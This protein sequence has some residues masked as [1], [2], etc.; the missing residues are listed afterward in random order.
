TLGDK[1]VELC[2]GTHVGATGELG[3]V[4]ITGETGVAAGVRR[5]EAVSGE[6]AL[7]YSQ[8]NSRELQGLA[9][10]LKT[11][12]KDVPAK[13]SQLQTRSRELSRQVEQLQSKLSSQTGQDLVAGVELVAGVQTLCQVIDNTDAK[14]LRTIV[15]QLKQELESYALMLASEKGGKAILICAVS[16]DLHEK[17]KAGDL[18]KI[19]AEQLG[20]RG[21][22]RADMAQ[23]GADSLKGV[24][25]AFQ[26]ARNW[27]T[28][29]FN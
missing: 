5:I 6:A 21:G 25:T 19:L 27:L 2:G 11:S 13:L 7:S 23:G 15:D 26:E 8:A 14:G 18:V 22:G 10:A 3:S 28:A 17:V 4:R 1:S 12:P 20:G 16:S 24:E 9:A 29:Q